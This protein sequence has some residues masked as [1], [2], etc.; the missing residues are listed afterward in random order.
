MKFPKK[1][2]DITLYQ[3]EVKT[4]INDENCA[5][6]ID[7]NILSQLYRLNDKARQ[8]FYNWISS[9][10]KRFHIPAWVIHEYSDKVFNSK[11][12]DY[13]S[14]LSKIKQYNSEFGNIADFVKGYIG[15]SLLKGSA[16]QDQTENL[17]ND[18]DYIAKTLEKVSKAINN[19]L[20]KHQNIVHDEIIKQLE[21]KVLSSDIFSIVSNAENIFSQ[22]SHNRI[23]PGYKDSAK[24][25]N[26]MGDYIIW[27][28]ILQFCK[29]KEIKKA[30]LITRDMKSDIVYAPA[31]QIADGR[32]VKLN[33]MIK[34]A[35]PCLVHEFYT[36]TQSDEF[37]IIDFKTFVKIFAFQYKELAL[38]FQ[39]AIAEEEKE[40]AE[41]AK[42]E[43]ESRGDVNVEQTQ[44]GL[45]KQGGSVDVHEP[46]MLYSGT[47]ITDGQYENESNKGCMD[48]Y[49]TQLKTYNWYLQNPAIEKIMKMK[50][51]THNDT[52]E[53][54]SSVFVL[55][56][57]LVQAAEGGSGNAV[58][59][60]ENI[61]KY[62]K[63]WDKV[64][65]HALIDGMLYEVYFNSSGVIRP[66]EFKAQYFEDII[67]N[68]K[69]LDLES[70]YK[71]IN[72]K[73][74][75]INDRFVPVVGDGNQYTFI[76]TIDKN[77]NTI[78]LHCDDV[79]ISNTFK[80]RWSFHFADKNVIEGALSSYY[81]ILKKN[82]KVEG[83]NEKFNAVQYIGIEEDPID[84]PF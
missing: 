30:I 49:I 65:K 75:K 72:D 70:P 52:L 9:C 39:L 15:E 12:S 82:I 29:K 79:D 69:D 8:D 80:R 59:F 55:G 42:L 26:S 83:L 77:G 68:T 1:N 81:G 44:L 14:E 64:F 53:N 33:K 51:I 41:A 18:I 36:H 38:S 47:A 11:T 4:I 7:T 20:E 71:F 27:T 2:L 32:P 45:Q 73:L 25:E 67:N 60:M 3:E 43:L 78:A 56:R 58:M 13:L 40:S 5:I 63:G 66:N 46:N 24:E 62:V 54:R 50:R 76:F 21:N 84:L 10:E 57:N 16:Y 28:E 17:K 31:S 6:F 34:I 19:N 37:Y 22:R 74:S 35:K 48:E 23:P 61:C